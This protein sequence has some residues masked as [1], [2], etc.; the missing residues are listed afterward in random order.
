MGRTA[1]RRRSAV[2]FG[3]R[4]RAAREARG[5]TQ[6]Q[7]SLQIGQSGS[8]DTSYISNIENGRRNPSLEIILLIADALGVDPSNLVEGLKPDHRR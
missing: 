4:V 6:L 5:V 8:L 7:L 2:E 3:K 1:I